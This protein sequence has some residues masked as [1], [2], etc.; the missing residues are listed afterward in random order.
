MASSMV[1]ILSFS[2]NVK[3]VASPVRLC[4]VSGHKYSLDASNSGEPVTHTGQVFDEKDHRRVRFLG[5]QKEVNK[6]F[7]IKLVA[8]EPVTDVTTRVVSCD[9]GGGALGHPKVYLNLD[10]DTKV[11]TCG[12]CGKRFQ[13]T[14]HH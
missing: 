8:E 9:G 13:Q 5:R 3:V 11:G 2:K 14:H 1:R 4:A 6:N 7:A 10:K 12:Y